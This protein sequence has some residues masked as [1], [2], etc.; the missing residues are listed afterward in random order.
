MTGAE[1][2]LSAPSV[3][4]WQPLLAEG[5]GAV[6]VVS[7][8]ACPREKCV[9]CFTALSGVILGKHFEILTGGQVNTKYFCQEGCYI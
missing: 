6:Q 7:S 4:S 1:D 8:F 3:G 9:P 5:A 2:G